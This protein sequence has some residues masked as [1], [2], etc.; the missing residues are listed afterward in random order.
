MSKEIPSLKR[1]SAE[2]AILKTIDLLH[3][4]GERLQVSQTDWILNT[5]HPTALDAHIVVFVARLKDAGRGEL[6]PARIIDYAEKQMDTAVERDDARA[7]HNTAWWL[8]KHDLRDSDM[9]RTHGRKLE[10][11]HVDRS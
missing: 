3:E 8:L 1:E 4:I 9:I 11:A 5:T 7:K 10:Q 2:C 6:I